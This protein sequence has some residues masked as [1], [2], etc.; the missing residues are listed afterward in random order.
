MIFASVAATNRSAAARE[1]RG[2]T[3]LLEE[4]SHSYSI[5]YVQVFALGQLVANVLQL[6]DDNDQPILFRF[7]NSIGCKIRLAISPCKVTVMASVKRFKP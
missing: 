2:T 3:A 6:Q 5:R 1:Y 4:K 7:V